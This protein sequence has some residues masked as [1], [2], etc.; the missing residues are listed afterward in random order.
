[1]YSLKKTPNWIIFC[2]ATSICS[3]AALIKQD[4][5]L[6]I[7]KLRSYFPIPGTFPV[8]VYCQI[9]QEYADLLPPYHEHILRNKTIRIVTYPTFYYFEQVI[10]YFHGNIQ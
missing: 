1:M 4:S 8:S 3:C 6:S 5:D 7:S 9:S 2:L 10:P